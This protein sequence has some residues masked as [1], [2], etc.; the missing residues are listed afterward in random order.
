DSSIP[1]AVYASG[2]LSG[3][4]VTDISVGD[5]YSCAV[6]NGAAYCWGQNT[7]GSLGNNSTTTSY[8]PVAV[9]TGGALSGKTVT[10][11]SAGLSHSCAVANGAAY[12][13]GA[14]IYGQLG[15]G[16]TTASSVPVAVNTSGVL[17]GKT[18]TAISAG[19]TH[20][21]AIAD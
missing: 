6:A 8:V 4:T 5:Q 14:N 11:V 7:S 9:Y 21:C 13:W 2:V 18:V 15:I 1:V 20:T 10:A 3:K 19:Q 12:C 16:A 17:N